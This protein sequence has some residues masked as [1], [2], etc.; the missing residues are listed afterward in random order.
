[1]KFVIRMICIYESDKCFFHIFLFCR[2]H[3]TCVILCVVN[4]GTTLGV[5]LINPLPYLLAC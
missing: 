1:M 2:D 4:L 3:T 5:L